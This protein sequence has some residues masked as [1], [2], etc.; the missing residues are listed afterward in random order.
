MDAYTLEISAAG[1]SKAAD[2]FAAAIKSLNPSIRDAFE[3]APVAGEL[4]ITD[5]NPVAIPLAGM[6]SVSFVML[7]P[8]GGVKVRARVSSSDGATQAIPVGRV[9]V[10]DTPDVQITAIDVTRIAGYTAP[11]RVQYLVGK[12]AA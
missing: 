12:N 1:E 11:V 9:L 2:G 5:D 10:I 6:S 8:V 3:R 7:V 4:V